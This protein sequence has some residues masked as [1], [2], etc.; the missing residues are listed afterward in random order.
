MLKALKSIKK[1]N[2]QYNKC[3]DNDHFFSIVFVIFLLLSPL[4]HLH[5]IL[6]L[7]L[8]FLFIYFHDY[9]LL[10]HSSRSIHKFT[11]LLNSPSE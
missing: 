3:Y 8:F 1:E 4:S 10:T 2:K 11:F 5:P 6:F 9:S 7:Y